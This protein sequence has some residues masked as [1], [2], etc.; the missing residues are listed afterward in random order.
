VGAFFGEIGVLFQDIFTQPIFNALMLLYRL[1]GDFGLSIVVLTL[2]IKLILFPL[3]LQQLKS[4]KANQALQPQMQEI[5]RKYA[6]DQQGQAIAMQALYKEYGINPLAGCLPLLIQ[7]PVLYGMYFAFSTVLRSTHLLH[8]INNLLYPFIAHFA[9]VN[10]Y[11]NWFTW[12]KFIN[13]AWPWSISLA[14]PDPT[15]ILPVIAALATFVQLRM[16]LPKTAPATT[17]AKAG[18]PDPT[19]STMKTM[20]YIM[21]FFTL[22][23][24]WSLPCGLALYWTVSSIFQAI[25]QYF[26]TG[27]GSLLIKPPV[28]IP[29]KEHEVVTT[30]ASSNGAIAPRKE[31][32]PVDDDDDVDGA[33]ATGSVASKMSTASGTR[34]S[35]NGSSSQSAP[36]RS[37]NNSASARRR[38][39]SQRPRR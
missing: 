16:S 2:I 10:V 21:P 7:L 39:N 27:W 22:F 38:S 5:R 6:K 13:P 20:Q 26:V 35:N 11:L 24:G 37:R 3:T 31:R 14:Q 29:K 4:T 32:P 8:D 12:L 18:Q 1:F 33:V 36:R 19:T 15:H 23:I 30:S 25:Q 28:I 17:N 9:S 34:A